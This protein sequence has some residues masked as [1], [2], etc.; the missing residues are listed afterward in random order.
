MQ[1]LSISMEELVV[2]YR[3]YFSL[4][5]DRAKS[6]I[7]ITQN[8]FQQMCRAIT[9]LAD[10]FVPMVKDY[11][12]NFP[13]GYGDLNLVINILNYIYEL[14]NHMKLDEYY[15][16]G[17]FSRPED[18]GIITDLSGNRIQ[19]TSIHKPFPTPS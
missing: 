6:N 16:H 18:S 4:S 8:E 2:M 17:E 3:E 11:R 7:I 15:N 1:I 10:I 9:L 12:I 5:T 13:V 14:Q 19:H